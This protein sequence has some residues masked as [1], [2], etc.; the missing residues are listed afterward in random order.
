[1]TNRKR[2]SAIALLVLLAGGVI[3]PSADAAATRY[4]TVSAQ[5]L[6]LIHI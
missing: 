4:I 1:M 6:S 3:A 5:G 2:I